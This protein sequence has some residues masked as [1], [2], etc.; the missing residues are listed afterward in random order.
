MG[1]FQNDT[2]IVPIVYTAGVSDEEYTKKIWGLG[3][4]SY[5]NLVKYYDDIAREILTGYF[6]VKKCPGNHIWYGKWENHRRIVIK[7]HK[8]IY[9]R[10]EM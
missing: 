8:F 3:S 6:R 1:I 7:L 2:N 9:H 5:E 4:T 10:T